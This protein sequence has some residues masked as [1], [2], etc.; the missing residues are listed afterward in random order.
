MESLQFGIETASICNS[1]SQLEIRCSHES[2]VDFLDSHESTVDFLDSN[3]A[4]WIE[5]VQRQ[6]MSCLW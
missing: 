5:V 4:A 3:L 6:R 2:T 1:Y